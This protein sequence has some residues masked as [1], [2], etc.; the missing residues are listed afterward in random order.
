MKVTARQAGNTTFDPASAEITFSVTNLP[1]DPQNVVLPPINDLSTDDD[2]FPFYIYSS[3]EL[4]LNISIT[5]PATLVDG[6]L[7]PTGVGTVHLVVSQAGSRD[8]LP[9]NIDRTFEIR[10][11]AD[12]ATALVRARI[13]N[14]SPE[15]AAPEADADHDGIP[16]IVE[17]ILG[18]DPA[19]ATSAEG[20]TTASIFESGGAY[21]LRATYRKP[22][23]TRYPT[24]VEIA[25][26]NVRPLVWW[27][28]SPN[29]SDDGTGSILWPMTPGTFPLI[30]FVIAYP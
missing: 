1:R 10:T 26:W 3:S 30:R 18:S 20:R 29:F 16:N 19:S 9:V 4:P 15:E 5:G 6:I 21:Y 11:I 25:D 14:V 27:S 23:T 7:T 13:P 12:A 8:Y 2:P 28:L 24:A 22:R 17:Y